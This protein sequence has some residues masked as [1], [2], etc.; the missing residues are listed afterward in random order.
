MT[1]TINEQRDYAV[2]EKIRPSSEDYRHRLICRWQLGQEGRLAC[3]WIRFPPPTQHDDDRKR[4]A[5][6][7]EPSTI[8]CEESSRHVELVA[9]HFS[10]RR[11]RS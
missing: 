2:G 4:L 11:R 9:D 3:E 6:D 5:T 1:T 8:S 10:S 7:F